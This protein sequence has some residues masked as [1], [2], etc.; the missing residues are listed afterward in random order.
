MMPP[1]RDQVKRSYPMTAGRS[2]LVSWPGQ[3]EPIGPV[4]QLEFRPGLGP[5]AQVVQDGTDP[6]EVS[7][8]D[9][10]AAPRL[11]SRNGPSRENT[12]NLD[13]RF[14]RSHHQLGVE[15]TRRALVRDQFRMD[16]GC[17]G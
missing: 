8:I 14:D 4:A 15:S 7:P 11:A 2:A 17:S 16:H 6:G 10:Y 5:N 12:D 3:P 9:R 13:D 1:A